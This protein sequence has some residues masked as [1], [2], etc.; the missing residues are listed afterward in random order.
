MIR[1]YT[2]HD[3]DGETIASGTDGEVERAMW[4]AEWQAKCRAESV[5]A[6]S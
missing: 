3:G 1:T 5:A 4:V 2:L 6:V